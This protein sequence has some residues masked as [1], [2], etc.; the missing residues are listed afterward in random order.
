MSKLLLL[1]T[2]LVQSTTKIKYLFTNNYNTQVQY[3]SGN[4]NHGTKQA[5]GSSTTVNT[6]Y[7]L[8][9]DQQVLY[10]PPNTVAL[11]EVINSSEDFSLSMFVRYLPGLTGNIERGLFTFA[12]SSASHVVQLKQQAA[13]ATAAPV[14]VLSVNFGAAVTLVTSSTYALSKLYLDQWYFFVV[15]IDSHSTPL[16]SHSAPTAL[17]ATLNSPKTQDIS[18][19][20]LL[21]STPGQFAT[22]SSSRIPRSPAKLLR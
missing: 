17:T 8:Y 1:C 10:I 16:M 3:L 22:P 5:I 20:H 2:L 15:S 11:N 12:N 14:S 19:N 18:S 9:L 7:G 6:P 13:V 4:A 21:E